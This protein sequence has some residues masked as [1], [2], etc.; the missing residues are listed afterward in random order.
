M[1]LVSLTLLSRRL[2]SL[3]DFQ[4]LV[5]VFCKCVFSFLQPDSPVQS[6]AESDEDEEP[7]HKSAYQK[8]LSTL[9]SPADHESEYESVDDDDDEEEDEEEV[10][11]HLSE[12]KL[13]CQSAH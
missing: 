8:L 1:D 5:S 9:S 7:E 12:G 11:E 4:L 13:K 2:T 3:S 6:C 10:E